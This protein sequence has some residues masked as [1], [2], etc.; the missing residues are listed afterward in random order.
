LEP[1]SAGPLAGATPDVS[2]PAGRE[3]RLDPDAPY[4]RDNERQ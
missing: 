4:D 3:V 1:G 2:Q